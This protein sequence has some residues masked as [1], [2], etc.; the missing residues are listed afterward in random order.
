[1]AKPS[2]SEGPCNDRVR[3]PPAP[4]APPPAIVVMLRL[5]ASR[6]IPAWRL[7]RACTRQGHAPLLAVT[8]APAPAPYPPPPAPVP[9]PARQALSRARSLSISPLRTSPPPYTSDAPRTRSPPPSPPLPPRPYVWHSHPRRSR[10]PRDG[11]S[12]GLVRSTSR[13]STPPPL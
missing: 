9:L 8:A 7:R 5:H 4:P 13:P 3:T 2:A 12:I 6:S 11:P 1:M 10:I